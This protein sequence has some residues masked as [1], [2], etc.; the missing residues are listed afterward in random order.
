MYKF[1]FSVI[2][3]SFISVVYAQSTYDKAEADQQICKELLATSELQNW[4][5]DFIVNDD[6]LKETSERNIYKV[7]G[8]AFQIQSLRSDFYVKLVNDCWTPIFERRYPVESMINLLLAHIYNNKHLIALRH[9]QYGN[10]IANMTIPMQHIYNLFGPKM[11]MYCRVSIVGH[12]ELNAWLV[13][14]NRQ[15]QYIHLLELNASVTS[16]FDPN[17][18]FKGDFYA[19]IPQG[20]IKSLIIN[21]KENN[22]K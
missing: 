19:N 8:R 6:M 14:Y 15:A 4:H 22:N 3:M 17:S 16:L 18:T 13:F 20:N 21:D 12:N 10:H 7:A 2:F 1:V 11:E 5:S 9:H